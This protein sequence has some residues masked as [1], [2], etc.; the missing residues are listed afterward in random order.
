VQDSGST[1]LSGNS[2]VIHL[3]LAKTMQKLAACSI[4]Y[5]IRRLYRYVARKDALLHQKKVK[6]RNVLP[7][8]YGKIYIFPM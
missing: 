5:D 2:M 4:L 8:F 7:N 1:I 6:L 3:R